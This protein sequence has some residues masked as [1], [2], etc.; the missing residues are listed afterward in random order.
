MTQETSRASDPVWPD[1]SIA[2][3]DVSGD[4]KLWI[5]EHDGDHDIL[6]FDPEVS[7]PASETLVLYSLT[8]HRT[9]RFPRALVRDRIHALTDDG[10][11]AR[12]REDYE[13]RTLLRDDHRQAKEA[14]QAE[15][16]DQVREGMVVAHQRFVE[17]LGLEYQGVV[18]TPDDGRAGRVTRCHVCDIVLDGFVGMTCVLC[19]A[20]LCSCGACHCGKPSRGRRAPS[21]TSAKE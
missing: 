3:V 11:R 1:W 10:A 2:H 9:R 8:Q 15:R 5:G 14:E 20:V 19:S 7:D 13:R 12:A 21:T 17:N 6:V 4:G 16:L 18:I